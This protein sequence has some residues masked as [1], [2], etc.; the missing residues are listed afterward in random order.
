MVRETHRSS[1]SDLPVSDFPR[2]GFRSCRSRSHSSH[3]CHS[4]NA[5]SESDCL[6]AGRWQRRAVDSAF[7][8]PL[9]AQQTPAEGSWGALDGSHFEQVSAYSAEPVETNA[10]LAFVTVVAPG[11][12]EGA[13]CWADR[14]PEWP[15]EV[16]RE[17]R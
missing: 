1:H 10:R 2:A 17:S 6:S 9:R 4:L 8:R 12:D 16:D 13:G 3:S 5:R 7:L 14:A 11:P 15:A